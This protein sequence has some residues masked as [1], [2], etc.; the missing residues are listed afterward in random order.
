M[1]PT[2]ADAMTRPPRP[3][4]EP[5]LGRPEWSAVAVTGVLLTAVTVAVYVQALGGGDLTRARSLAFAVLVFGQLFRSFAS[6]STTQVFW[7][8]GALGNLKLVG[9]VVISVLVQLAI[10]HV[11]WT[12]ALFQINELSAQDCV[13]GLALGLVP[14]TVLEVVKLAWAWLRRPLATRAHTTSS[15]G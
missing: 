15:P 5:I 4:T 2:E 13:L 10:H 12:Q 6:R 7:Q 9:V 3:P 8:V 1:D 11:P 14:V